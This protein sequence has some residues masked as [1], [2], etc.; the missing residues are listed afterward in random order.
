MK[1]KIGSTVVIEKAGDV[2]PKIS[3]TIEVGEKEEMGFF[4]NP[5]TNCPFCKSILETDK[6]N[7][8]QKCNNE[9][10]SRKIVGTLVHFASKGCMD[11]R[12]LSQKNVEKL[13]EKEILKNFSD[14]YCLKNEKTKM[15]EIEGFKEKT[16]NNLLEAIENSKN[17]TFD[18]IINSLGIPLLSSFK[19][20]KL[21]ASY[22]SISELI[23]SI[24]SE[25]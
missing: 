21:M 9:D 13:F 8:F 3:K 15:L 24:K 18:K 4:W 22:Q 1:I 16:V 23:N 2:I 6:K 14:F 11:I 7:I 19:T 12:G 25:E 10:C 5:P 20:K 17:K